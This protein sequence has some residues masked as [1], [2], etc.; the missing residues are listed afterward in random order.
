GTDWGEEGYI[1][2][3]RGVEAAEGLCGIA[4]EASYPTA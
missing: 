4:M 3:Q 2:M 1:M